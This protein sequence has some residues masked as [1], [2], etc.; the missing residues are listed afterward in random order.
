MDSQGYNTLHIVTHSSNVM[1]LLYI[2]QQ[3]IAVDSGDVQ[4]HTALMW[5]AYQ[6]DAISIDILIKHGASVDAKD[7]TG[8][9]PLHWAVVRGNRWCIKKLIDVGAKLDVKDEQ[10]KTPRDMAVEL[11]SIGAYRRALQEAGFDEDGRK[12]SRL[13]NEV[14][15]GASFALMCRQ[16]LSVTAKYPACH[17]CYSNNVPLYGIQNHFITAMVHRRTFGGGRIFRNAPRT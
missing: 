16:H 17:L 4:G 5:A 10:G 8:M 12:K 3:P 13:L 14:C 1:S 6:G 7:L 2:L 9:T 11:K 15:A